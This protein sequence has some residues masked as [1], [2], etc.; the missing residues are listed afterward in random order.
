[1]SVKVT[2][3]SCDLTTEIIRKRRNM[4]SVMLPNWSLSLSDVISFQS[5][6]IVLQLSFST[7]LYNFLR[8]ALNKKHGMK[9]ILKAWLKYVETDFF[10]FFFSFSSLH[11]KIFMQKWSLSKTQ[12]QRFSEEWK[13][14]GS[15]PM[16]NYFQWQH[17]WC[18]PPEFQ[19]SDTTSVALS[20]LNSRNPSG[21]SAQ[22]VKR[23]SWTIL[24]HRF[25]YEPPSSI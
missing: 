23:R 8:L 2:S 20:A 22:F 15:W 12:F 14:E 6:S 24:C 19:K 25:L 9:D 4:K 11:N 5:S 3:E 17:F 21:K 10:S 7:A 13:G 16:P 18:P 1:M